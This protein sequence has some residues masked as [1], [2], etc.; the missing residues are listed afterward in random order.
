MSKNFFG[1]AVISSGPTLP[2]P[3]TIPDG[4]LFMKTGAG[5]GLYFYGFTPDANSTGF[6]NQGASK[7]SLI[8]DTGSVPGADFLL[9]KGDVATGPI[10]ISTNASPGLTISSFSPLISFLESSTGSDKGWQIGVKKGVFGFY[11]GPTAELAVD[12]GGRAT[13]RGREVWHS[14]NLTSLSQLSNDAGFAALTTESPLSTDRGGTGS[15]AGLNTGGIIYAATATKME[16]TPAGSAG[17]VLVSNG[18]RAPVWVTPA[19]LTVGAAN[20]A[21]SASTASMAAFATTAATAQTAS[22]VAWPNVVGHPTRLSQ[23]TDDIGAVAPIPSWEALTGTPPQVSTFTND[24]AYLTVENLDAYAKTADLADYAPL[25]GTGTTGTWS[26]SITGSAA[27]ASLSTSAAN[28]TVS[29]GA[30]DAPHFLTFVS[31]GTGI[32]P[33]QVASDALSFNPATGNLTVSGDVTA[34]SDRR[35]KDNIESIVGA[36]SKVRELSGVNFT[37]KGSGLRGTGMIAQDVL[38]VVPEAVVTDDKGY[39]SLAY[40]NLVGLLVEAIKE[41]QTQIDALSRRIDELS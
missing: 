23:F 25:T 2:T 7:W 39:L 29:E 40:G 16:S 9:R 30:T 3:G 15:N 35:L 6:G 34:A 11:N 20:T 36:V 37:R 24:A 17:Q 41:Q 18:A 4:A 13:V 32:Q 12:Q 33:V 26:I 28:V 14:G 31:G 21:T 1:G 22:S 10:T 5:A 19:Q 38:R 8:T 27:T